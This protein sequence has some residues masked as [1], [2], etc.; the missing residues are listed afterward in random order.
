LESPLPNF[1]I[2]LEQDKKHGHH[3]P[4]FF[5]SENFVSIFIHFEKENFVNI[6]PALF[7]SSWQSGFR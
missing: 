1:Q 5:L 2:L 4:L 6:I 3:A 7:G